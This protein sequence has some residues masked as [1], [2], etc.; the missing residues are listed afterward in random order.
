MIA[1]EIEEWVDEFL[2]WMIGNIFPFGFV[3][4][5]LSEMENAR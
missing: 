1:A 2:L 3:F 5:I 4:I